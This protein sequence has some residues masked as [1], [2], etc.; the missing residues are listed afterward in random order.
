MGN[1]KLSNARSWRPRNK[2]HQWSS[3]RLRLQAW[4]PPQDL[5]VRIHVQ[6][7]GLWGPMCRS[8][9]SAESTHAVAPEKV[10][11]HT[12]ELKGYVPEFLLEVPALRMTVQGHRL[13]RWWMGPEGRTFVGAIDVFMK[14]PPWEWA[15]C[16]KTQ[17]GDKGDS[18]ASRSNPEETLNLAAFISGFCLPERWVIKFFHL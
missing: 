4:E 7:W 14:E 8:S 17:Q 1:P 2:R 9:C 18:H 11:L 15:P 16:M 3:A 5:F 13:F 10:E 6:S 12:Q